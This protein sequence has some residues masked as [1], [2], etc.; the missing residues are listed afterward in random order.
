MNVTSIISP[1]NA[2]NA[3]AIESGSPGEKVLGEKPRP[4]NY[5]KVDKG[6]SS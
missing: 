3:E 6:V 5:Q 4:W 1:T 2:S